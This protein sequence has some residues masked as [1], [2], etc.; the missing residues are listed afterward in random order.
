MQQT[1][2]KKG[3]NLPRLI[4]MVQKQKKIIKMEKSSKTILSQYMGVSNSRH[5]KSK[6]NVSRSAI[7]VETWYA[8]GFGHSKFLSHCTFKM[9]FRKVTQLI[10]TIV[11]CNLEWD[12]PAATLFDI[13]TASFKI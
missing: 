11:H 6:K 2:Q 9:N 1:S 12:N 3:Q 10:Q 8:D 4:D 13:L 7:F 5:F